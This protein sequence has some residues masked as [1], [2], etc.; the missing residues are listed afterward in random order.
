MASGTLAAMSDLHRVTVLAL[1][2]AAAT[3]L[4]EIECVNNEDQVVPLEPAFYANLLADLY[5]LLA[6]EVDAPVATLETR[7]T[8]ARERSSAGI[9]WFWRYALHYC[10]RATTELEAARQRLGVELPD[11]GLDPDEAWSL[12]LDEELEP[13]LDHVAA[14]SLEDWRN[15]YDAACAKI[16]LRLPSAAWVEFLV[17]GAVLK[18]VY[19]PYTAWDCL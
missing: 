12:A 8:S 16:E 11:D 7:P 3:C 19:G 9:P 4:L 18:V 2:P 17:E 1:D 5:L 14:S 13:A 10:T 6:L 15:Q